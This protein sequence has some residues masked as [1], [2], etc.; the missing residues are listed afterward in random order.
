M[1]DSRTVPALLD[2]LEHDPAP[3]IRIAVAGRMLTIAARQER[4]RSALRAAV[5]A[6]EMALV[7]H[8]AR[9]ALRADLGGTA[10]EPPVP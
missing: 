9:Y 3:W 2:R 7:R 10:A 6:D 1:D 8:A 4:V 5:T